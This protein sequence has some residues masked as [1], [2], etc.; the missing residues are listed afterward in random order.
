MLIR[1][2]ILE[3]FMSYEFGRIPLYPG[4]NIITG[5]NGAGK[6]SILL[7]IS[8]AL[9]TKYT[10][11]GRR[12]SDLIR[13]GS[14]IARVAVIIDN[15][16]VNGRRPYGKIRSNT[17]RISRYLRKDGSYWFEVNGKV[18]TKGEVQEILKTMGFNP[19]NMLVIMHQNMVEE[20]AIVSSKEKLKLFE[21]A[22]GLSGYRRRVLEM[23]ERLEG[24][25]REE[26]NVS[27]LLERAKSTLEYWRNEYEK[28]RVRRELS[29]KIKSLNLELVWAKVEKKRRQISGLEE[30][31]KRLLLQS[32]SIGDEINRINLELKKTED[33][34]RVFEFER[35]KTINLL[36]ESARNIGRGDV[37]S[38]LKLSNQPPPTTYNVD[39]NV[40]LERY[41]HLQERLNELSNMFN[42]ILEKYVDLK[43]NSGI[44]KYKLEL[45][46]S[47]IETLKD[48]LNYERR[49]EEKLLMEAENAGL[50]PKLIRDLNEVLD[51]LRWTKARLDAVGKVSPEA[52]K[53][54][55]SY[56]NTVEDL[57]RRVEILRENRKMVMEELN[58]RV[59]AWKKALSNIL[60][61]VDKVYVE[62]LR[63][64]GAYGHVKLVN[65]EDVENA[66][67]EILVGFKG[68]S[69]SILNGFSQSGGER[70]TAVMAF[71]L[72]VQSFIKSPFR[73][74]DEFD[75][76]MDPR[77]REIISKLLLSSF[78]G[79]GRIQCLA[80]T[81]SP[82]M[83]DVKNVHV[84]FVQ[85]VGGRSTPKVV[86]IGEEV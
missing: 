73:A 20:F 44:L 78:A 83:M 62:I 64:I 50:K 35:K 45:L 60:S 15:K 36:V 51:E 26:A 8:V 43:V 65:L 28:L 22:V 54:Y 67:L 7:A 79:D 68:S 33:R 24:I 13:W 53:L 70:T 31:L 61:K 72:A 58:I 34:L 74:V 63:E 42:E 75:V 49:E 76:H 59:N 17:I 9:G 84:I 55:K 12:L 5:P 4:L 37:L 71:L 69:P 40:E 85:N 29:A 23:K 38:S 14:K 18:K 30:D 41:T 3:N 47:D 56:L 57:R 11:R 82:I 6:S 32:Q 86:Q 21:D 27:S 10:E 16:P 52:E 80:I 25:S 81:P 46:K 66:G 77:N 19:D 48:R 1:E 2:V 39:L